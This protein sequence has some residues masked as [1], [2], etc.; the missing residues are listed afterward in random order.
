VEVEVNPGRTKRKERKT[1]TR[2]EE[3]RIMCLK[4]RKEN[5]V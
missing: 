3:K 2:D 1:A 4:R 5:R